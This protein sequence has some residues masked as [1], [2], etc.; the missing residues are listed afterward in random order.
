MIKDLR[1][2]I[3]MDVQEIMNENMKVL[4]KEMAV[5][6]KQNIV[7]TMN[8]K[9]T[10]KGK[11]NLTPISPTAP[12]TQS[13]QPSTQVDDINN[14]TEDMNIERTPNKRK[15]PTPSNEN[16]NQEKEEEEEEEE[17]E[18]TEDNSESARKNKERAVARKSRLNKT[19]QRG[20]KQN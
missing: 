20:H 7:D 14:L 19:Q 12:I 2:T 18:T 11:T 3:M 16:E 9:T 5:S 13:P 4:M 1:T 10:I 15:A 8:I 6:I 17:E